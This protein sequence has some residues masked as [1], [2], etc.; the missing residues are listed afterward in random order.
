MRWPRCAAGPPVRACDDERIW[1]ANSRLQTSACALLSAAQARTQACQR[2][3]RMTQ[4]TDSRFSPPL[5]D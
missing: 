3:Q 4:A 2:D 1:C 5:D